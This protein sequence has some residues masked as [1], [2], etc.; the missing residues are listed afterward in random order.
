MPN[1]PSDQ[2]VQP[3]TVLGDPGRPEQIVHLIS[4]QIHRCWQGNQ[5]RG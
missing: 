4:A 3:R 5:T 1:K 2:I